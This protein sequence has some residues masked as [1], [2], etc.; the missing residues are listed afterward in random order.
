VG[1]GG[2]RGRYGRACADG[3]RAKVAAEDNAGRRAL[4]LHPRAPLLVQ[5]V[6]GTHSQ[7]GSGR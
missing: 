3:T 1:G 2:P 4:A 6:G 5:H 7:R